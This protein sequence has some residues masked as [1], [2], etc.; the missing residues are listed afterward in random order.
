M[1]VR[2][3]NDAD[4]DFGL[5]LHDYASLGLGWIG[6]MRGA[7]RAPTVT[8]TAAIARATA[9]RCL[10][11]SAA[12]HGELHVWFRA[13]LHLLLPALTLVLTFMTVPPWAW[14]NWGHEGS[15]SGSNS[16]SCGVGRTTDRIP[17]P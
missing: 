10:R 6:A 2:T 16:S 5:D 1:L 15:G 12:G 11:W 14:V 8:D 7:V 17:L 4:L 13:Q 9:P 3:T